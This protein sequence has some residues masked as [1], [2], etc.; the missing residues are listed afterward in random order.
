MPTASRSFVPTG[1]ADR[2]PAVAE[3]AAAVPIS[4]LLSPI[5]L[6]PLTVADDPE[7]LD[8]VAKQINLPPYLAPGLRERFS[9]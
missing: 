8:S 2:T 3:A 5:T 7:F 1:P 6:D 4:S 9:A